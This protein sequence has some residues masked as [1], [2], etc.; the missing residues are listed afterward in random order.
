[1]RRTQGGRI[2]AAP[3]GVFCL[4]NQSAVVGN[5]DDA[6]GVGGT[7]WVGYLDGAPAVPQAVARIRAP[8][9]IT[10]LLV[11]A[12]HQGRQAGNGTARLAGR[13]RT[14]AGTGAGEFAAY[15]GSGG[16]QGIAGEVPL[17]AIEP[18]AD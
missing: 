8:F 3:C 17:T 1:M 18:D 4:N 6:C 9:G 15:G 12:L 7:R 16:C 2:Y 11:D 14:A 5:I 13:V 10:E